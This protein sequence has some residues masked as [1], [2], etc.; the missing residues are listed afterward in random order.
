M[1]KTDMRTPW[2][3]NLH[4]RVI[5]LVDMY[6]K[7][8]NEPIK[9]IR[10]KENSDNYRTTIIFE[11]KDVDLTFESVKTKDTN[12]THIT[13]E[14]DSY[15]EESEKLKEMFDDR[16]KFIKETIKRLNKK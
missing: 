16:Y 13:L 14:V 15:N 8:Y 4:D 2:K 10:Y 7:K 5:S 3:E 1:F 6:R 12:W 9:N 11:F